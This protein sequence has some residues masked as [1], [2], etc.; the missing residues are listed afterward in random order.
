MFWCTSTQGFCA[1]TTVTQRI[2]QNTPLKMVCWRDD[3]APFPGSSPRWFYVY[4]DN[5]QEGYLWAPQVANQTPGTPNCS[6]INWINVA[7]WAIGHL[8]QTS[9]SLTPSGYWAGYCATFTFNAWNGQTVRGDA[10]VQYRYYADRGMVHPGRP[11]RGALVWF[12]LSSY[13]HVAISIGNWQV[14]GTQGFSNSQPTAAYGVLSGSYGAA[15]LGW[16]MPQVPTTTQN[17]S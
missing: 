16:T 11:P 8:N 15:Y 1:Q 10:I 13:G 2:P 17:P 7:D 6:T 5:G 14:V 12:N 9:T 4:L 3:R